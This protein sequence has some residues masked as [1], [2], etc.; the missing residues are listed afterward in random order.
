MIT[1]DNLEGTLRDSPLKDYLGPKRFDNSRMLS[2]LEIPNGSI[3]LYH[4][5]RIFILTQLRKELLEV[6]H[7]FQF[8]PAGMIATAEAYIFWPGLKEDVMKR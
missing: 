8:A 5:N 4:N 6:L 7:Q 3:L 1:G 2:I